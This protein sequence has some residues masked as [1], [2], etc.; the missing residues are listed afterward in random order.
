MRAGTAWFAVNRR[1]FMPVLVLVIIGAA[2]GLIATRLMKIEA[3]LITTIAIGIFGALIGGL[4]LRMLVTITGLA[5]G[6]VGAL[7]GA[8]AVIVFALGPSRHPHAGQRK[9][10]H[11]CGVGQIRPRCRGALS[12][13]A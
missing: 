6:F 7:P 3:D 10:Q 8:M 13:P 4:V 12:S 5:A 9:D 2:A 1:G 11:R